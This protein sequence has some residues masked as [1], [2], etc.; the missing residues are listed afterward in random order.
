MWY[1]TQVMTG[2]E[3]TTKKLCVACEVCS[4][5]DVFY[6]KVERQLRL[7]GQ[8][9]TVLKIMFPGYLFWELSSEEEAVRLKQHLREIPRMTK[10]LQTGNELVPVSPEEEELLRNLGG[11]DHIIDMSKGIIDGDRVIV[12]QGPLRGYEYRIKKVNR[13]NR[14]AMLEVDLCHRMIKMPLGLDIVQKI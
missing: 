14:M 12:S 9:R 1:V 6:F 10:L 7:G 3:E 2:S 4:E 11:E 13:H 5:E 8:I